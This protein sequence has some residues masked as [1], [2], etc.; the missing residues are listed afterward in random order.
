MEGE[1]EESDEVGSFSKANVW[2]R[3]AIVIAGATVNILFGILVYFILISTVGIQF[4][5]PAKDTFFNRI[6]YGAKGTGEFVAT[7]FDSIKT[8][9]TGGIQAGQ[10]VGIVGI[11]EVVVQTNGIINYLHLLAVI[12]V[13][14]GVTNLLP[15]PALDGGKILILIIEV[16]RRK[17]MKL[18][19]EAKIQLLGFSILMAL[20]IFVTY[21]DILRIGAGS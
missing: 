10:M 1:T 20:T 19:T 5:D 21:N 14:L 4:V 7:I 18:E 13:S 8:L 16:I 9:I 12:S 15:I 2:K 11:S 17:P 6:Y 3:M